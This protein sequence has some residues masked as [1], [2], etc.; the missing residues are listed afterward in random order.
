[1]ALIVNSADLLN[2]GSLTAKNLTLTGGH[3]SI[4]GLLQ[5][6]NQISL[7]S[8]HLDNLASCSISSDK[9]FALDL[10]KLNNSV[11]ITSGKT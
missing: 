8:G 5:G 1:N 3:F 9:D 2:F 4:G 6:S 7:H 10:Q 11:L